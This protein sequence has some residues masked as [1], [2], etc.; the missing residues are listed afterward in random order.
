MNCVHHI[1]MQ[2]TTDELCLIDR[3]AEIILCLNGGFRLIGYQQSREGRLDKNTNL[4]CL[5]LFSVEIQNLRIL[6]CRKIF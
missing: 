3:K 1:F 5:R 4:F 6:E 2:K